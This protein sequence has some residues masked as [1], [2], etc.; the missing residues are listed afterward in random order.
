V[1]AALWS[2]SL[3]LLARGQ[4]ASGF[5]PHEAICTGRAGSTGFEPTTTFGKPVWRGEREPIT[6]LVNA[7]FGMGDTIMFYRYVAAAKERVGRLVLR[8]DE[9]FKFLFA[10]TE[11]VGKDA[12][13]P[14]C[15]KVI[16]MMALPHALGV[17]EVS[18]EPYLT[19]NPA[20]LLDFEIGLVLSAARHSKIGLC[21]RGNP[22]NPRDGLRTLPDEVVSQWLG[23]FPPMM[24][25]F[26]LNKIGPRDDRFWDMRE[27]M[28]DWNQTAHLISLLDLVVSVDTAVAHLAGAMGKP[29]W[30]PLCGRDV[31]WRWQVGGERTPWYDSMRLFRAESWSE[32]VGRMATRICTAPTFD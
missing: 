20:D 15:D 21:T 6:L 5:P 25:F 12:E 29:V 24:R 1:T 9:D 17:T 30:V 2:D 32:L 3:S 13:L 7:D 8:C 27:Y 11:I 18:G 23:M 31:D 26:S 4:W 14:P 16:H 22:F 10:G 28:R 19:P